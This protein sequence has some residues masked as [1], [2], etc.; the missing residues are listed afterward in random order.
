MGS[1]ALLDKRI[2]IGGLYSGIKEEELKER[3]SKFGDVSD[4]TIKIRKDV[5]GK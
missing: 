4:I 1:E 3:F 5:D 2:H